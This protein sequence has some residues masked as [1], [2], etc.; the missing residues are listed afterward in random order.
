M[1]DLLR[2]R[3]LLRLMLRDHDLLRLLLRE[4]SGEAGL[5]VGVRGRTR[6]A[7]ALP[8]RGVEESRKVHG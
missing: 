6:E 1:G 3:D 2:E 8:L 5:D 7:D 4:L